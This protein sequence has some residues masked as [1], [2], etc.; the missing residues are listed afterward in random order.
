M[1]SWWLLLHLS[2]YILCLSRCFPLFTPFLHPSYSTTPI[3]IKRTS[4]MI[5][6]MQ[7]RLDTAP[8]QFS[9]HIS[10][11]K[12]CGGGAIRSRAQYQKGLQPFLLCIPP[13]FHQ[14]KMA[15]SCVLLPVPP[16]SAIRS[17]FCH[18]IVLQ[19]QPTVFKVNP[20]SDMKC[21]SCVV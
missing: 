9:F 19:S 8:T 11:L 13:C 14:E 15:M 5:C 20:R 10:P 6:E 21:I 16:S 1:K 18:Y 12:N 2:F 7:L 4:Y 17:P 3:H